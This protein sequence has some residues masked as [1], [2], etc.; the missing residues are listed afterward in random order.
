MKKLTAFILAIAVLNVSIAVAPIADGS[1]PVPLRKATEIMIPIGKTGQK[2]S[3]ADFSKLTPK[4]YERIARVKLNFFDRIGYKMAMKNLR[5]GIAAD[6]TIKNKRLKKMFGNC[7]HSICKNGGG[8]TVLALSSFTRIGLTG[9]E[10][11]TKS[12]KY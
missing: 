11:N 1:I 4:E 10:N 9:V 7:R 12:K 2:I 6:G 5:K 8:F 3:L